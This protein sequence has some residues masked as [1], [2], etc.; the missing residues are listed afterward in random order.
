M[1]TDRSLYVGPFAQ[2]HFEMARVIDITRACTNPSC[3]SNNITIHDSAVRFCY[4]CGSPIGEIEHPRKTAAVDQFDIIEDIS[5][6]LT[7]PF[8][9]TYIDWCSRNRWHIYLPNIKMKLGRE[10]RADGNTTG[11]YCAALDPQAQADE[12]LVFAQKFE[13][14]INVL[15]VTY[16]NANVSLRWGTFFSIW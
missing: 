12:I 2:C 14:E 10:V 16:G 1:G 5:D 7:A 9:D 15:H 4:R 13:K 11:F 6:R 3:A 8:G